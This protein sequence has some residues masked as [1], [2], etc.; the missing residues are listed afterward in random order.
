MEDDEFVVVDSHDVPSST[1]TSPEL[2]ET[3]KWLEPTAYL[4]E[5]SELQ[6][7][8]NWLVP[9]TGEWIEQTAEFQTWQDSPTYGALWIKATAGAG[10]S[11]LVARLVSLLQEQSKP[12]AIPV[13]FFFF[14][15]IVVANHGPHSLVRDWLAQLLNYSP[16]L[17]KRLK[18]LRPTKRVQDVAFNELWQILL[19]TLASLKKVY[20]VV[21]ALDELDAN[22]TSDF[23]PRLVALGQ[24]AP[25]KIKLVMSSRPLPHIQKILN[26]PTV[27]QIRLENT[28]VNK[29]I[30]LFVDYRLRQSQPNLS[31]PALAEI[32]QTIGNRVH[33]SFLYARLLLN[34]LLEKHSG[35]DWSQESVRQSL[36]SIPA[37]LEDLYTQMLAEHSQKASVP[38]ER[39]VLILRLV[40][41]ATRPLRLLEIATVLDFVS[42]GNGPDGTYPDTKA[43]TRMSC[44]PLLEILDDETVS[45]I[46]HSFTEFLTDS[47]RRE[48]GSCG[49]PVIDPLETHQ[50]MAT[51]CLKYMSTCGLAKGHNDNSKASTYLSRVQMKHPFT[52]YAAKSWFDHT[53]RLPELG[54]DVLSELAKFTCL[55]QNA[56][57]GWIKTVMK[58]KDVEVTTVT[59]LHAAAWAGVA[60]YV[61]T[62]LVAGS[63]P[64]VSTKL[65]TTPLAMAAQN[66][67]ADAV[68][69]LLR[70]GAAPDGPDYFGM[71]PL[72]Y[73]AR[74]NHHGVVQALME[75][76]VSPRT[77]KTCDP[78]PRPCGNAPTSVGDTPL[79]YACSAGAVESVRA[80]MPYFALADAKHAVEHSID[81]SQTELVELLV[82]F[83]GLLFNSDFGAVSLLRAAEKANFR[84]LQLLLEK[85]ADPKYVPETP[86]VFY[87]PERW[88]PAQSALIALAKSERRYDRSGGATECLVEKCLDLL[89][90]AGCTVDD[91][92]LH[93]FVK[94]R[95]PGVEKLLQHGA[96]VNATD[97]DGN[98]PLHLYVPAKGSERTLEALIGYGARW[99]V[100]RKS[101]GKTPLHTCLKSWRVDLDLLSP[102]ISDW[103]VPDAKGNTPLHLLDHPSE[104]SVK[105]LVD[106]GADLNRRN[107]AGQT[108]LHLVQSRYDMVKFV[109]AGA[110]LEARDAKG[111][112][113]LLARIRAHS[114]YGVEDL[115]G[116]GANARAVDFE[117]NGAL[118]LA[119]DSSD[120]DKLWDV[121]VGAG[122]DPNHIN[123]RGDTL[124]HRLIESAAKRHIGR[125][126]ESLLQKLLQ[127]NAISETDQNNDGRTI[128]HLRCCDPPRYGTSKSLGEENLIDKFPSSTVMALLEIEDN[129][130]RRAIHDAAA[131]SEHLVAWLIEKG[132]TLTGLTHKRQNAL[133]IAAISKQSNTLGLLLETLRDGQ[134]QDAVNQRDDEGRTP[135]FYACVS[136]Y[137][138][139]VSILLEAGADVHIADNSGQTPLHA[140]AFFNAD[141][142]LPRCDRPRYGGESSQLPKRILGVN[143]VIVALRNRGANIAA[144]DGLNRTPLDVA[145]DYKNEEMVALLLEDT[146]EHILRSDPSPGLR[147]RYSRLPKARLLAARH[148]SSSA[149]TDM[150][151]E[152]SDLDIITTCQWLLSVR[153]YG[154]IRELASRGLNLRRTG[155]NGPRRYSEPSD[156]LYDLLDCGHCDL[157]ETLGK[158]RPDNN[159]VDGV[160]GKPNGS[161]ALEPF[162]LRVVRRNSPSVDFLKLIVE[163]FHADVNIQTC[164]EQYH[165]GGYRMMLSNTAVAVLAKGDHWWCTEGLRYLLKHG[166]NPD[167]CNGEGQS[168]LHIVL[169]GG[170]RRNE[171][172]RILLENGANPNLVDEDGN[173]PLGLA[174]GNAELVRLLLKHG[175]DIQMGSNPILFSAISKQDVDTVRIILDAGIDSN[176]PF[177]Q[178]QPSR[179]EPS[180]PEEKS[181][182]AQV[183]GDFWG[184]RG[185]PFRTE[186]EKEKAL[187]L[188]RPLHFACNGR[189]NSPEKRDRALE[190]VNLLLSHDASP[191]LHTNPDEAKDIIIHEII[192]HRGILGPL[193]GH[194]DIDLEQRDGDGKTLFLAACSPKKPDSYPSVGPHTALRQLC[195][196][197]ADLTATDKN[198][199][200]AIHLLIGASEELKRCSTIDVATWIDPISFVL[201]KVPHLISQQNNG[202]YTPFHVAVETH[203]F[204][205]VDLLIARGA[206]PLQ[207]DPK[208]N[209][210]LH[211]LPA[212]IKK[213]RKRNE[214]A[215]TLSSIFPSFMSRGLDIN[216]RNNDRE[217]PLFKYISTRDTDLAVYKRTALIEELIELGADIFT[218][219]N[220]GENILHVIARLRADADRFGYL[221]GGHDVEKGDAG[222]DVFK[223]FMAKGL[224]PFKEDRQQRSAVDVA[225]AYGRE[226]ILSSL[227]PGT[228]LCKPPEISEI[229]FSSTSTSQRS[230]PP[231]CATEQLVAQLSSLL[232]PARGPFEFEFNLLL[233]LT[234]PLEDLSKCLEGAPR[235]KKTSATATATASQNPAALVVPLAESILGICLASCATYGLV[236]DDPAVAGI[237]GAGA[238]AGSGSGN[239]SPGTATAGTGG[240]IIHQGDGPSSTS[241]SSSS[242]PPTTTWHCVK[243][244][245][246]LGSLALQDEEEAL[247][248]RQIVC[249]VLTSLSA[250]LREVYVREK[251]NDMIVSEIDV[252]VGGDGVG[253]VGV[254]GA[255][256]GGGGGAAALYGREGVGAV[257][258]ALVSF[259][260]IIRG[261]LRVGSRPKGLPAGPPTEFIW[262]NTKQHRQI[263][264]LYPQYQ[265]AKWAQKYGPVYTVMLGDT[266]HVIVS[267]LREVRDIFIKQGASSQNRP[268]SRFQLLM[269]DGFFPGL[270]NGE[271]WRQS[272]KMWQAILNG[273]AAKQYLPYQELET[274]QLLFDLL[275]APEGWRDHVERYSNSVAMTMVNGR[276]IVDAADPRIKETI[277]DLYDLAETGVRGAFLDS[278]P[279]LW[280]LPEWMFP[281]R[282]QARKIAAKHREFIWRNYSDVAER[283]RQ[284]EG[285]ALPSVN[286]AIQEKLR[287][288][289]PGVSE[290][291]GAEIGHHLLTGTTD[292][293][294]STLINWVA[295]MCL[296]PEAQKRAQEEIDRVVG[297]NRLPTDEDAA[298]LPYIQQ[299]IQETQ[300]WITAVPLSLP[301]AANAPV[302]WGKF[303]IPEETGLI[304]NSH[305]VH[306]DPD[307]FP[308]P[309][310]FIPERWRG[311]AHASSNTNGDSQLLFT[312]GTGRRVCPGQHLA[313]RSLFLVVSHW[314]WG[315]DTLQAT[316]DG[317]D[318]IPIDKDDLRP[319]FIVC[320]NP[321]AA[322]ITPRTPQHRKVIE[323]TWEEELAVSLDQN[324]QWKATPEGIARLMER[325]GK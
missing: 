110:D 258:L 313:E 90:A 139:T 52:D 53:R 300:R 13:L 75:V 25:D 268:P 273:S 28:Q 98:T 240:R 39:Q 312:F 235:E 119:I 58:L 302:H 217:T 231:S 205:L 263:N 170:Y 298:N 60:N 296:Y 307:I 277:Q 168:P 107:H 124:F 45:I 47:M 226:K 309:D 48:N 297:P 41:H 248:A 63:D 122:A 164:K 82:E 27:L 261:L 146:R 160:P 173:T 321:F 283:S 108:P 255:A 210:I 77:R 223:F 162:I 276:R 214:P 79:Q 174:A 68:K 254:G 137:I 155:Q 99:D 285:E 116:L 37:S 267:G 303:T 288:G 176:K 252:V 175:A 126:N 66:G 65:A 238:G 81:H 40:T 42:M 32:R 103:N 153:A 80:M 318:K 265:Y 123:H 311:K 70:H 94:K 38:Q 121:L 102:Y 2:A 292:T 244:P 142:E 34:E 88:N 138:E 150:L 64:N 324:Q 148:A 208:G 89:L 86:T 323:S 177:T 72:H 219:N 11:V 158:M 200:N 250:L 315:F 222:R 295:A 71:K 36:V 209:T 289:W 14:R 1:E 282:K 130:G 269:R 260:A 301:R 246:A 8:L 166:A 141:L 304:M 294:A 22:H 133:H 151:A 275:R 211:H 191:F 105:K 85:G 6:Q 143:A 93:T 87:L 4:G 50:L 232:P 21:D 185:V 181:L 193:I 224:D 279:F 12:K 131:T 245:M 290:I 154:V 147:A 179:E 241:S 17:Q 264:L 192:Y 104:D 228:T 207:P 186:K 249:V 201:D 317:G 56:F 243:T 24:F 44:G 149:V 234:R 236:D 198:G 157:F 299:V 266:A 136:G 306:N 204:Y 59:P 225:A 159:W 26:D 106:L 18:D 51:I 128:L 212:G 199:N 33:P 178:A 113:V 253:G 29:D 120:G 215:P 284:G 57:P 92:A 195:E 203:L 310:K 3:I 67:H 251:E 73:A 61:E 76:N 111:R 145:I 197:G 319:G 320:L 9:G 202:G 62:L 271:K 229:M 325:V 220:A 144:L 19:D 280:N 262:G 74:A 227:P 169:Q 31:E 55:E 101:D 69:V 272:R 140:C 7:H 286:H 242:G 287:Q 257:I 194:P 54:E 91:R 190:I 281:V 247:L 125:N 206:D 115:I 30:A 129:N 293:T 237:M 221:D 184:G 165:K 117:G 95:L 259:T 167:I 163:T 322:K 316:D 135:L 112:T 127:L 83:P 100:A 218:Q 172:V 35:G 23:L 43:M 161:Q 308:E 256:G 97:E 16:S 180:E 230:E 189:H 196:M 183:Y 132:A 187:L 213:N 152:D 84:V 270:N 182:H 305:A 314:L 118:G 78:T 216:A 10:K 278:W 233:T 134:R 188:C 49:F 239:H 291:E 114:Q 171:I 109:S 96:S 156:F 15:Q 20:C 5:S 46:H 274:R